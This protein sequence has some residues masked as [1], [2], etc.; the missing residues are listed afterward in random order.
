MEW[1]IDGHNLIGQMADVALDD[2]DDEEKLL[3]YLR[4]YRARTGRRIVVVFDPGG[5]Y[6]PASRRTKGGIT[7]Q[8]APAGSTADRVIR[9]RLQRAKNPRRLVVVSSDRAVQ[10]AAR[11]VGAQ[12]VEATA[13]AAELAAPP[14]APEPDA[15]PEKPLSEAEIAEWLRLFG[16]EE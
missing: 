11:A 4:R 13:F 6:H 8:Y 5:A 2:P 3:W 16:E 14:P 1:L 7:V 15:E 10:R 12:V 9:A